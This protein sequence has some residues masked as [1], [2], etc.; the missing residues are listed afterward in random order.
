MKRTKGT[1]ASRTF[2]KLPQEVSDQG[3]ET[4]IGAAELSG[5]GGGNP[6][7]YSRHIVTNQCLCGFGEV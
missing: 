6:G 4:T 7:V 1:E 3:Q 5:S 2:Q